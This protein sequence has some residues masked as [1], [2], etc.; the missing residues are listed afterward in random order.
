MSAISAVTKTN[1]YDGD[2]NFLQ[3]KAMYICRRRCIKKGEDGVLVHG[4]TFK[5]REAALFLVEKQKFAIDTTKVALRSHLKDTQKWMNFV[6][7]RTI[8]LGCSKLKRLR[9]IVPSLFR[10]AVKEEMILGVAEVKREGL[11]M[12]FH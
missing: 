5:Y 3:P 4:A 8:T 1:V 10:Y 12:V 7:M 9:R 2:E 6:A 11:I